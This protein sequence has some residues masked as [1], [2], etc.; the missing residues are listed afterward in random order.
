MRYSAM[1]GDAM[2]GCIK[3]LDTGG[4]VYGEECRGNATATTEAPAL[5]QV[6]V[7]KTKRQ[8]ERGEKQ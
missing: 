8:S 6:E 7:Q 3:K 1:R 4:C 2:V 5:R